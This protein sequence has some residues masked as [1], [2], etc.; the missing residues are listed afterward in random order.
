MN[1]LYSRVKDASVQFAIDELSFS[2]PFDDAVRDTVEVNLCM[3]MHRSFQSMSVASNSSVLIKLK[4]SS[5]D[6]NVIAFDILLVSSFNRFPLQ[7]ISRASTNVK[8]LTLVLKFSGSSTVHKYSLF[9]TKIRTNSY[10]SP[11][12]RYLDMLL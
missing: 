7:H 9:H 1:S 5:T 12:Q 10:S 6:P 8:V 11:A 4:T 2:K 3:S